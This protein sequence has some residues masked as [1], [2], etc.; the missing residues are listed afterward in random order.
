MPQFLIEDEN[1]R[2][3]L[4]R[5]SH[6]FGLLPCRVSLCLVWRPGTVYWHTRLRARL[7]VE[8]QDSRYCLFF[9]L[10]F[11][12][13]GLSQPGWIE[14]RRG[15]LILDSDQKVCPAKSA[16]PLRM[17]FSPLESNFKI[18]D[19]IFTIDRLELEAGTPW[20]IRYFITAAFPSDSLNGHHTSN[21]T[22]AWLS[23]RQALS[24]TRSLPITSILPFSL[25]SLLA[26]PT[27]ISNSPASTMR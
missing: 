27:M 24:S 14:L 6:G 20:G 1:A 22:F 15:A 25:I 12:L 2:L 4:L 19:V 3:F 11:T 26:A 9:S 21:S 13:A 17:A 5:R 10:E 18:Q 23:I 7:R 8:S 16:I